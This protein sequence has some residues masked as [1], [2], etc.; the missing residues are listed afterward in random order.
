M[1]FI[2][3]P[4]PNYLQKIVLFEPIHDLLS[5]SFFRLL[6]FESIK[7]QKFQDSFTGYPYKKWISLDIGDMKHTRYE[8]VWGY[9]THKKSGNNESIIFTLRE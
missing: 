4:N 5:E 2:F 9:V 1:T 3:E 7:S 8:Y 6:S